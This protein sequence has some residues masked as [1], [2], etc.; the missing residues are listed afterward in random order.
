MQAKENQAYRLRLQYTSQL[1]GKELVTRN[2]DDDEGEEVE[3]QPKKKV[4]NPITREKVLEL[5]YKALVSEGSTLYRRNEYHRAIDA[6]T[7]ALDKQKDDPNILIDRANCY[8][9]IGQPEDALRDVNEVLAAN[10]ENPRAILTK[11]EAYF[12]MGEFEFAL[13][14]FQRGLA[15]RKDMSAFKDGVTKSKSAI[16]DSING[17][18]PFQP[19]PNFALSRP[20]KALVQVPTDRKQT[21]TN[22][23]TEQQLSETAKLLPENVLPLSSKASEEQPS[24]L[25]ELSLDYEY[26]CELREEL[27]QYQSQEGECQEKQGAKEDAEISKIV[28]DGIT[29]LSQRGSFWA[30]QGSSEAAK[31]TQTMKRKTKSRSASK[32]KPHY[33]MS[34]IEQYEAKYGTPSKKSRDGQKTE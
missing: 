26:L 24:F 33:E 7:K 15:V 4:S 34:K 19:N 14:F 1:L 27:S 22:T 9:N 18:Q 11:A 23:V 2:P 16:L 32:Q 30:Q 6:F 29:F 12:S 28:D 10:P 25:G 13:V 5:E 17:E 8:I 21:T 31:E 3:A 20:R